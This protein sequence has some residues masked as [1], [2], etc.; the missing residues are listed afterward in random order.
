MIRS[1]V[2]SSLRLSVLVLVAAGVI[3]AVVATGASRVAMD[4]LPEFGPT[5]VEVQTE[6]LGLSASEV[7]Q[8]I[9]VP[10]EDEFNGVPYVDRLVSRSV[11]GLSSIDLIFKPG[12]DIYTAR[13]L[14]TERV[15]QG[16]S[17]VNVGTPPVMIEPLSSE[18]RVMM[19]ALSSKTVSLMDLSTTA[20]W[21]I[22]PRLLAVPGVAGVSIWG[23]R[24]HQLQVLIDPA[25]AA[26]A[27]V[28]L[29]QVINTAGDAT[30]TS[31]LSFLEASSPGADG[32]IDMP[33]QRLTV[34]HV[35]PIR[36]AADLA[37]V[38][39]EDTGEAIVHLGDVASVVESSPALRGDAV[40]KDG[41]GLIVVVQKL[42]GANTLAVSQ[43]IES[44]MADLERG[45]PGVTVDST[46]FRPATFIET[47]S[48][49]ISYAALAAFL[50][51]A[52]WLGIS[53][54]SWRV[55][56]IGAV[57]IAVP[58]ATTLLVLYSFGTTF[59][60]MTLSG[61]MMA[62][63]V[64]IDDA[65]V[66]TDTLR[67][68]LERAR[69]SEDDRSQAEVICQAY[70]EMRRPL[71]WAVAI[72]LLAGLPLLLVPRV[73][74][75][76]AQPIEIA[77]SL[78]VLA[79]T[80]AALAVTPVLAGLLFRRAPDPHRPDPLTVRIGRGLHRGLSASLVRPMWTYIAA[81]VVVVAAALALTQTHAGSVV[82]QLQDRNVLVQ[83][84]AAPGTSLIEMDRIAS[85]AGQALRS[86]PG[87]RGVAS[88][89]G[90]ALM[91]DQPVNVNSAETWI[92]MDPKADYSSTLAAIRRTVDGYPGV[93]H[94]VFTYPEASLAA[95]PTVSSKAIT[96][97]LYG[98]DQQTLTTESQRI[99]ESISTV[100]GVVADPKPQS[101]LEEPSVQIQTDIAA[102]A[103]YGLKPG[104]IRRQTAVLIA[105]IAVGSYYHDEQ[106]FD[107]TVW[108]K[109]EIRGSLTDI[110][111]L[112]IDTPAG[113]K[114]L[115]KDIAR[116][117]VQ[118]SLTEIDHDRASRFMD[119]TA[120]VAGADLSSTLAQVTARVRSMT[121]PLGYHA[122]V[123]SDL[124]A[125]QSGD[126]GLWMGIIAAV[127]GVFLLLQ[128]AFRSWKRA[129]LLFVTLPLAVSG[130]LVVAVLTD[131]T[132]SVGVV[133]G[134]FLV[135]GMAVRNGI[136]VFRR[137]QRVEEA[138]GDTSHPEVVADAAREVGPR[139][140]V[141]AVATALALVP[142]VVRGDIAGMEILRPFGLVVLGGLLTSTLLTLFVLPAL[143][144]RFVALTAEAESRSTQGGE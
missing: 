100:P 127:I 86:T 2:S 73:V 128:A 137:F 27:G 80:A 63:G 12:T 142:F 15:A 68:H 124:Q 115:L 144:P 5:K 17:V 38:P 11:P 91:G 118:P 125:R 140:V 33:N 109:P 87:V 18:G 28:S 1:I 96:V 76:F 53:M 78:A 107:V 13:Q 94:T 119:V 134:V 71:G 9:T 46:V 61:L 59:N 42:P 113:G 97:R 79:S 143:Y 20:L 48:A 110:A 34:Q 74:G 19:V 95:A 114:V 37:A 130:A 32:L 89:V 41:A 44:A 108:S 104:D 22:R 6:A 120:D 81:A 50:L 55:T 45:M 138:G 67:R 132:L 98:T 72:V 131:R 39:V 141:A 10:L 62:L 7:E 101:Q 135:L 30:W 23:Q 90:Q 54:R 69:A 75:S 84:Q 88:H 43:G 47:S 129:T 14:V 83:W 70:A 26:Q 56:L 85:V 112:P 36:S 25:R 60:L 35:L 57:A 111:N 24:D 58:I 122:E 66:G 3:L 99:R 21:R 92:T 139:I 117:T 40:L 29:E 31:P 49:N 116:V 52:A 16:P 106:I 51:V 105:G 77:F 102:A 64:I 123:S 93:R 121:L 136:V 65:V 126:G 133:I 103:H 4:T 8:F 82:P